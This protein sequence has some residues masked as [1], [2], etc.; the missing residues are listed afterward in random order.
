V[1]L[2]PTVRIVV[3]YSGVHLNPRAFPFWIGH[4]RATSAAKRCAIWRRSVAERG[5]V[6]LNQLFAMEEAEI[7]AQHA[8]PRHKG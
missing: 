7:L 6:P 4:R 3:E 2:G 8:Q 1:S 5:F